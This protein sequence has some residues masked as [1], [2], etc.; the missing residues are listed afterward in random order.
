MGLGIGG[1]GVPGHR[2]RTAA[3]AGAKSVSESFGNGGLLRP[4]LPIFCRELHLRT[5]EFAGEI[6]LP[7]LLCHVFL[8]AHGLFAERQSEEDEGGPS[9]LYGQSYVG[10]IN[11]ALVI[12]GRVVSLASRPSIRYKRRSAYAAPFCSSHTAFFHRGFRPNATDSGATA[13]IASSR[14]GGPLA[15]VLRHRETA[16]FVSLRK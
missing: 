15:G 7:D 4:G 1:G 8:G 12:A 13:S 2:K 10:T 11:G 6:P 5:P 9:W 16:D 14:A 3:S